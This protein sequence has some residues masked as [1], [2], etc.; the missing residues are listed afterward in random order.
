MQ[1]SDEQIFSIFFLDNLMIIIY[2]NFFL[3][4]FL[5][6]DAPNV[7]S[8]HNILILVHSGNFECQKKSLH[9]QPDV[10]NKYCLKSTWRWHHCDVRS[11]TIFTVI[12][13]VSTSFNC[14]IMTPN[15]QSFS[16]STKKQSRPQL[17]NE[18]PGDVTKE[19]LW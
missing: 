4:N 19:V 5:Y 12:K 6:A 3:A 8:R 2:V 17:C 14:H 18:S 9:R 1:S 13:I 11:V 16:D 10:P 7:R 15:W